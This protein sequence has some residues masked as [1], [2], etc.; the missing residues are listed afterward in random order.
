[1]EKFQEERECKPIGLCSTP[2][3]AEQL[4]KDGYREP[5]RYCVRIAYMWD[6]EERVIVEQYYHLRG[7]N[8]MV[9]YWKK[10]LHAHSIVTYKR[11]DL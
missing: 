1:M 6:K 4:A 7:I 9:R 11:M 5:P 2:P 8:A 10:Y 3:Q